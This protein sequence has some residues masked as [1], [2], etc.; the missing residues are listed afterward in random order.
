MTEAQYKAHYRKKVI[1]Y[2][3]DLFPYYVEDTTTHVVDIIQNLVETAQA[4]IQQAY[5]PSSDASYSILTPF[6]LSS[7][8]VTPDILAEAAPTKQSWTVPDT[9]CVDIP[10]TSVYVSPLQL[11]SPRLSR[12]PCILLADIYPNAE[13]KSAAEGYNV[14]VPRALSID[15]YAGTEKPS[16]E[17]SYMDEQGGWISYTY[18][19]RGGIACI[20]SEIFQTFQYVTLFRNTVTDLQME[21]VIINSCNDDHDKRRIYT[22]VPNKSGYSYFDQAIPF[23]IVAYERQIIY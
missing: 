14:F 23:H 18:V 13:Q 12:A 7:I 6:S 4:Q 19:L 11:A 20:Y 2:P 3:S 22:N 8:Y 21:C 9:G 1:S 10:R 15:E 5:V 17:M 16:V